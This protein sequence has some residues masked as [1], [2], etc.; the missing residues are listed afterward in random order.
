MLESRIETM[1]R[2]DISVGLAFNILKRRLNAGR[3]AARWDPFIIDDDGIWTRVK[4]VLEYS[5]NA[6]AFYLF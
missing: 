5:E 2:L 3:I 6:S 1:S 4:Y